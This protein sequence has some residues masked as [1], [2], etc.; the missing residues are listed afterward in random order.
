MKCWSCGESPH[1][2]YLRAYAPAGRGEPLA[3]F[4][5]YTG[6]FGVMMYM[7]A[8]CLDWQI[9]SGFEMD[10]EGWEPL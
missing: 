8:G 7:H 4:Y 5:P 10:R 2:Q 9:A 1:V 6:Q 3:K